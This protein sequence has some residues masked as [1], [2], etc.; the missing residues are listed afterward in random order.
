M[1]RG[2]VA[3]TNMTRLSEPR[4]SSSVN[5][6]YPQPDATADEHPGPGLVVASDADESPLLLPTWVGG[7]QVQTRSVISIHRFLKAVAAALVGAKIATGARW[8]PI[9]SMMLAFGIADCK[10]PGTS[11]I[12]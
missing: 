8:V 5:V 11:R 4:S 1:D 2:G 10:K 7:F 9:C 6:T 12:R 3:A